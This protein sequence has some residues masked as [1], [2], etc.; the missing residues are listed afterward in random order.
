M[1]RAQY[2]SPWRWFFV[3]HISNVLQWCLQEPRICQRHMVRY[4]VHYRLDIILQ[5]IVML[6][7][8]CEIT[9]LIPLSFSCI[10]SYNYLIANQS[11]ECYFSLYLLLAIINKNY[12]Q[13]KNIYIYFVDNDKQVTSNCTCYGANDNGKWN[14]LYINVHTLLIYCIQVCVVH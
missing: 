8:L 12:I 11:S 14:W 3:L 9:L 5:V 2:F 13:L 6:R 7:S 4:T 1:S 10:S